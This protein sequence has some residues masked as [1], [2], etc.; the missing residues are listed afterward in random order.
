MRKTG[1]R[2]VKVRVTDTHVAGYGMSPRSLTLVYQVE[3]AIRDEVFVQG[4]FK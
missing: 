4:S 1:C 2:A 3:G